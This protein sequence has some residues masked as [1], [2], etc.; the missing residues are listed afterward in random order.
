MS[1]SRIR[2]ALLA[3]GGRSTISRHLFAKSDRIEL[4]ALYD[5]D[6]AVAE[7]RRAQLGFPDAR[8]CGSCEEALAV[9]GVDWAMVFSPN[10]F[11]AEQIIA[12]FRAGKHVFTEKPL[13]ISIKECVEIFE[14]H[15]RSGR[16]FATGFVLRFSPIYRRVKTL[17]DA[18][19]IGRIL[20]I[21]ANENIKAEHGAYIM[22]NWRR[23]C[24]LSGPHILEKC[25][26]DLDL[27]N[28]FTG[29]LPSRVASFAG[30]DFFTPE[31][32]YFNEKFRGWGPEK[33]SPFNSPWG[34]DPHA[35]PSP[36]TSDKDIID[37][38]VTILQYRNGMRATFQTTLSN[39]IPERRM[40]FS[41]TEGTLIVELYGGTVTWKR[42]DEDSIHTYHPAGC[43]GHGG[44]DPE[45][46]AE[47]CNTMLYGTPPICSGNEGL[48]SA[49]TAL[50]IDTAAR[51]ERIFN[52]EPVL[53][54]LNR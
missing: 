19:T 24:E 7:E 40:F 50:A 38:Q 32:E 39:A 13:A 54:Q 31:H 47:L 37:N 12:S 53:K 14:A 46:M 17:L 5:P 26:H 15:R 42:L 16:L 1:E 34:G 8:I 48:D 6:R 23:K 49:V 21:D 2:I 35:L 41:G 29:S 33:C 52:L 20:C 30:L 11:H 3:A 36:F 10:C 22:R 43:A 18:G 25:C 44:G 28:W 51:E 4:A 45:I 27:L 9:P